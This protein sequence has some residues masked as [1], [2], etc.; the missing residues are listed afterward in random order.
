[1]DIIINKFFVDV[2]THID[3]QKLLQELETQNTSVGKQSQKDSQD[4]QLHDVLFE[5]TQVIGRLIRT[6]NRYF[7]EYLTYFERQPTDGNSETY[8]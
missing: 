2:V 1:M 7:V 6:C 4:S 3:C 8:I 5:M